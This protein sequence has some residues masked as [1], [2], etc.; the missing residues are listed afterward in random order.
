MS[1][2]DLIKN[3]KEEQHPLLPSGEWEGFYCYNFS[4]EQHKMEIELN[5]SNAVVSGSGTDDVAPF[6]WKGKYD[7]ELFKIEMTK[8]YHSHTVFYRGDIDEN[9]IWGTWEMGKPKGNIPDFII[10]TFNE[11]FK[12]LHI[13][14]FHIWPKNNNSNSN[15]ATSKSKAESEKLK[16][17]FIE[18]FA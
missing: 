11:M 17:I 9:G 15:H 3:K 1:S 5:F 8:Y 7:L 16:E 12:E 2:N 10:E 6:T 18:E 14:G 4:P 13:G